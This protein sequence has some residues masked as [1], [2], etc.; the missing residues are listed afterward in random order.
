MRT[1]ALSAS[2]LRG[3]PNGA[4]PAAGTHPA[5]V[6]LRHG[7]FCVPRQHRALSTQRPRGSA[8][9][10][11]ACGLDETRAKCRALSEVQPLCLGC[12]AQ[13]RGAQPTLL[14]RVPWPL[15]RGTL[16]PPDGPLHMCCAS[17]HLLD[18]SPC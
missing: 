18:S 5:P 14:F 7:C 11:E 10:R 3:A 13:A 2:G 1:E 6:P 17:V 8:P 12:P 9:L 16:P 4:S 15:L